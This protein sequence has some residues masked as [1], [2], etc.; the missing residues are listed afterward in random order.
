MLQQD[1]FYTKQNKTNSTNLIYIYTYYYTHKIKFLWEMYNHSKWTASAFTYKRHSFINLGQKEKQS[2]A[3]TRANNRFRAEKKC[4]CAG[5][6][7]IVLYV[8]IYNASM[9]HCRHVDLRQLFY[10]N[11]WPASAC[12]FSSFNSRSSSDIID[13]SIFCRHVKQLFFMFSLLVTRTWFCSCIYIMTIWRDTDT[14][15]TKIKIYLYF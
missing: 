9:Q 7:K 1:F 10:R 2:S 4:Q 5:P 14:V 12:S 11:T 15:V 6:P 13:R 8:S 3:I